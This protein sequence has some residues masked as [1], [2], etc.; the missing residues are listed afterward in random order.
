M[1]RDFQR[2]RDQTPSAPPLKPEGADQ[3]AH[4]TFP[5]ADNAQVDP[6]KPGAG[7]APLEQVARS[8]I[9]QEFPH[10]CGEITVGIVFRAIMEGVR[11]PMEAF[12]GKMGLSHVDLMSRIPCYS[13][14]AEG[15]FKQHKL[16]D[17][18]W[19]A[20]IRNWFRHNRIEGRV[21]HQAFEPINDALDRLQALELIKIDTLA[22]DIRD[23]KSGHPIGVKA[24]SDLRLTNLGECVASLCAEA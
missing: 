23:P 24:S 20:T 15:E 21:F 12:N 1:N 13:E 19:F 16:D 3:F 10:A 18:A 4:L 22:V 17:S 2:E 8:I 7:F 5:S 14:R 6:A 9:E 11:T